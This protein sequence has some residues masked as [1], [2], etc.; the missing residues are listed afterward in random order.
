MVLKALR[1]F[2]AG[3]AFF[4]AQTIQPVFLYYNDDRKYEKEG[5]KMA[6]VDG[7]YLNEFF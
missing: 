6:G 4:M 5:Y 7:T 1:Q 2:I 3:S